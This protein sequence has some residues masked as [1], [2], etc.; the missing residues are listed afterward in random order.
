MEPLIF[1][2]KGFNG[3]LWGWW[4]FFS[5]LLSL[6]QFPR[7]KYILQNVFTKKPYNFLFHITDF[8]HLLSSSVDVLESTEVNSK[9]G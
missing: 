3:D 1:K 4:F 6:L 9:F 7:S 2:Y 8:K 5:I